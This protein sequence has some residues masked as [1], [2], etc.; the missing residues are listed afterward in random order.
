MKARQIRYLRA[1]CYLFF[2]C[3][4][5]GGRPHQSAELRM[6]KVCTQGGHNP[7]ARRQANAFALSLVNSSWLIA[8][9]SSKALASAI[10]DAGDLATTP[11]M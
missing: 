4:G 6:R 8:P 2:D 11:L 9:E 3:R 7:R 10:S 1:F 5:G